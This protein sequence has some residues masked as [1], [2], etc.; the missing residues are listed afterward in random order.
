MKRIRMVIRGAVQGVGYRPFIYR[1]AA[2]RGLAGWVQNTASGVVVEAEGDGAGLEAFLLTIDRDKPTTAQIQSF[3]YAWLE[4]LGMQGFAIRESDEHGMAEVAILPDLAT[5]PQCLAEIFDRSN[6]RFRYPFTNCTFCGPRYSIVESLPYDRRNTSMR[7]FSLC[8]DCER[9]YH[10]PDDRRFHAQPIA[11]PACGPQVVLWDA[12]G[13]TVSQG[14]AAIRGAVRVIAGGGIVAAKGIGGFHLFVDARDVQAVERLRERKHRDEKPFAVLYP[15]LEA[16]QRDAEVSA[17]ERRCLRSAEAPIV[18]LKRR[19]GAL[20]A[21]EVA[22]GNP[23]VGAMLPY[24]PLHHLLMRELGIPV[25]A[26][27]GNI[28]DEPICTD[29]QDALRRLRGIA[30]GWLV[31]NRPIVRPVD[32]SVVRVLLG[33]EQ[34][35]RRARGYAPLPPCTSPKNANLGEPETVLALGAQMKSTIALAVREQAFVS[36]HLGDLETE[37]ALRVFRSTI[38]QFRGWYHQPVDAVAVDLHP[39]YAST[40]YANTTGLRV[41][42]VQHHVAHV[43]SC[44]AENDLQ[45]PVLG[46]AWDGTGYGTDQTIWGGEFLVIDGADWQRVGTIREFR[47]PGGSQAVREPRRSALGI[48]FELLGES[49]FDR[50]EL[51]TIQAFSPEER[52]ILRSML[53]RGIN[54]PATTS[55]GRLFDAIASLVGV[56]QRCGFEGQAAMDVEFACSEQPNLEQPS[57]EQPSPEQPSL[58]MPS[59]AMPIRESRPSRGTRDSEPGWTVDWGPAVQAIMQRVQAGET[60]VRML[61]EFHDAL[62]EA[63]VGIARRCGLSRV[64]LTG[65]CFQN[66]RLAERAV[67][68]LKSAGFSPFW[69]QRIPP[70]DGGIALGQVFAVR[71]QAASRK[72]LDQ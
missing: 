45:G 13:A 26:T 33:G 53:V 72:S 64:V 12:S 2:E 14:D 56:R 10:D 62:A 21:K 7:E 70:N 20:A 4:P 17:L 52:S 6:R 59:L 58:A 11:C 43:W 16:V 34:L 44:V 29:E 37:G 42:P 71:A 69:H 67:T 23:M 27:S 57:P 48:L 31:H 5:C 38:D 28:S 61:E 39:D 30:D 41:V 60:V 47:L 55:M 8:I 1:M 35:L 25:V 46:V 36:Q 18:I 22:P 63:I 50:G 65:G 9:E 15:D 49:V 54:A 32:D 68:R 51:L 40:A 24:S 3:E 19:P 66:R